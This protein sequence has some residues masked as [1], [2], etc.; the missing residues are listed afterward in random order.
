MK[1]KKRGRKKSSKIENITRGI[2]KIL[3]SEPNKTFN[4]RQIAAKFGV[5]DPSSRNQIVKKLSQ[6]AAKKEIEELSTREGLLDSGRLLKVNKPMLE[7]VAEAGFD[8]IYGARPLQRA[9]EE[10]LTTPLA[11]WLIENPKTTGEITA[12]W[13]KRKNVVLFSVEEI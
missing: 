1:R 5:D 13:N 4:Y 2:L 11:R 8:P 12:K 10:H 9:I 7:K 6:L 3:K